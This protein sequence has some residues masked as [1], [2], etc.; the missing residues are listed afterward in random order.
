LENSGRGHESEGNSTL[1]GASEKAVVGP[2]ADQ[3]GER[4]LKW[5]KVSVNADSV[6]HLMEHGDLDLQ[7]RNSSPNANSQRRRTLFLKFE[8]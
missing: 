7:D 4:I 1:C 3:F 8:L 6:N 5:L 2:R